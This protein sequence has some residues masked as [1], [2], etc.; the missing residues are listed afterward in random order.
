MCLDLPLCN[1]YLIFCFLVFYLSCYV[2]YSHCKALCDAYA[3][4]RCYINKGYL[5]TTYL[6]CL[7]KI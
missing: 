3:L 4:E 6:K 7:Y 2:L 5:L 1:F